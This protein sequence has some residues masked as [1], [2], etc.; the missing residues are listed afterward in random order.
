V[1][2]Y[3]L[4][5]RIAAN[6]AKLR[7][8]ARKTRRDRSRSVDARKCTLWARKCDIQTTAFLAACFAVIVLALIG[9]VILGS[10]QKPADRAFATPYTRV[11]D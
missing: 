5:P 8:L 3:S 7:E 1:P 4:A 2:I 9:W 6:I 10:V 11:G